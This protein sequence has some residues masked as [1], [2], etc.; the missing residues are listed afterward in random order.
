MPA[1]AAP[2]SFNVDCKPTLELCSAG[3]SPKK[4]PVKIESAA[5]K[6]ST[7]QSK[8]TPVGARRKFRR[9]SQQPLHSPF[10]QRQTQGAARHGQQQAFGQKLSDKAQP[11]RAERRP[12]RDLSA[13]RGRAAQQQVGDV[14]AGDQ[15]DEANREHQRSQ[16]GPYALNRLLLQRNEEDAAPRLGVRVLPLEGLAMVTICSRACSKPASGF[17]R[18]IV[19]IQ[20]LSRL[21]NRSGGTTSGTQISV[22]REGKRNSGGITPMTV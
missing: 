6:A 11:A 21:L 17:N 10:G 20:W 7:R 8:P 9:K 19:N 15:Q 16:R 4:T 1:P 5:V 14:G 13:A 22:W 3:I 12:H 18:A 2:P